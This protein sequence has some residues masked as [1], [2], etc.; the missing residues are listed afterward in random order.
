[1]PREGDGRKQPRKER[2]RA[3]GGG[4]RQ[5]GGRRAGPRLIQRGWRRIRDRSRDAHSALPV[6]CHILQDVLHLEQE[7]TQGLGPRHVERTVDDARLDVN[8]RVGLEDQ[9]GG[10]PALDQVACTR[11]ACLNDE[12]ERSGIVSP[13]LEIAEQHGV[14]PTL[15]I[16]GDQRE[17]DTESPLEVALRQSPDERGG[18]AGAERARHAAQRNTLAVET[19]GPC[20]PGQ[21]GTRRAALEANCANSYAVEP[22]SWPCTC[23]EPRPTSGRTRWLGGTA[24]WNVCS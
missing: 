12:S 8:H 20:A 21:T 2:E 18:H 3:A 11:R 15:G 22:W 4:R 16:H 14:G 6:R 7:V 5:W 13:H 24:R 9:Q 19:L 1:N 23:G 10:G 17:R